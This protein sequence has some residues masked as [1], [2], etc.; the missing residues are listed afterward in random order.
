MKN[1]LQKEMM[2]W[3]GPTKTNKDRDA[4]LVDEMKT[5]AL[6]IEG[7]KTKP[8]WFIYNKE[9]CRNFDLRA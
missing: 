4:M 5:N 7:K 2:E 3:W 9:V 8:C 1:V 6:V